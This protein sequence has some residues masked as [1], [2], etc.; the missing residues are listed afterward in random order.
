MITSTCYFCN[1]PLNSYV[2]KLQSECTQYTCISPFHTFA[3]NVV[4]NTVVAYFLIK[5]NMYICSN[6]QYTEIS[7]KGVKFNLFCPFPKNFQE[8]ESLY[9]RLLKLTILS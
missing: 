6:E 4:N 1:Q 9:K 7:S 8:F 2:Q 3:I 5:E